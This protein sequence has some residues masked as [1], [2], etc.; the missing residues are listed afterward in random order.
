MRAFP[1]DSFEYFG[2]TAVGNTALPAGLG[3]A[4]R[5]PAGGVAV[6]AAAVASAPHCALR[7]SRQFCPLRVPADLAAW[8][9]VLHSFIVSAWRGCPELTK[10]V[11]TSAT[12]PTHV[13]V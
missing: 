6:G 8:Y 7:K 10:I 12:K 4:A 1:A 13:T 3:A 9:L 2:E 5:P 11:P